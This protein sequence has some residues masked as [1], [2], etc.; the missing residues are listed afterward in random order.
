[1]F[2]KILYPTDFSEVSKKALEFIKKFK[3]SGAREVVVLHVIDERE[4]ETALRHDDGGI[5]GFEQEFKKQVE[6][7]SKKELSAVEAELKQS[8]FD[9]KT[10]LKKG[11]PFREILRAEDEENVSILVIG[12]HGKSAIAEMLLGSVSENVIRKSTKPVLV[13]RR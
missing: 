11:I 7:I 4:I 2:K 10:I 8:G 3:E 13:V 1:M 9:V 12:S 6:D 5:L